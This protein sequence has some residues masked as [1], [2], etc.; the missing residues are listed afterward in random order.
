M[1]LEDGAPQTPDG[2]S[3]EALDQ[4]ASPRDGQPGQSQASLD[5]LDTTLIDCLS[6]VSVVLS[7]IIDCVTEKFHL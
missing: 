1:A 3:D 5:A 7:Q 6:K 4:F 2:A